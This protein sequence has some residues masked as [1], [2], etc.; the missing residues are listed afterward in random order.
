KKL[1]SLEDDQIVWKFLLS[2]LL[3]SFKGVKKVEPEM[4]L[5]KILA[6]YQFPED[7]RAWRKYLRRMIDGLA[8]EEGP[9]HSYVLHDLNGKEWPMIRAVADRLKMPRRTLYS[10][11]NRGKVHAEKFPAGRGA[12]L[13]IP[14]NE[15][16]R[17]E[18]GQMT[19][20]LRKALISA[21]AAKR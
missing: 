9:D 10:L 14:D 18:Q 4:V 8:A 17:L 21:W 13:V 5:A 11:V 3:S 12:Y 6:H 15:V 19:K 20:G 1:V 7:Y 16:E 2:Y